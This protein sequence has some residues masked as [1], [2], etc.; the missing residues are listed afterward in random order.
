MAK[1]QKKKN[2]TKNKL[3]HPKYL[4]TAI[5]SNRNPHSLPMRMED[6]T[7]V[8]EDSLVASYKV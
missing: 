7:V 1:I 4:L 2:K 3:D 8:L 6:G 5:Q